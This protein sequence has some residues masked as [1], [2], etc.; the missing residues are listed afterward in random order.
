MVIGHTLDAW[1]SAEEAEATEDLSGPQHRESSDYGDDSGSAH[2][3]TDSDGDK[4]VSFE[5]SDD[6][7]SRKAAKKA[8]KKKAERRQSSAKED[9]LTAEVS[10]VKSVATSSAS[11]LQRE[12]RKNDA[13]IRDRAEPLPRVNGDITKAK[14]SMRKYEKAGGLGKYTVT[15]MIHCIQN[16]KEDKKN[17]REG[18]KWCKVSDRLETAE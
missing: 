12:V 9:E 10:R 4:G 18:E 3:S 16:Q 7:T 11:L 8:R 6:S 15:E 5:E 1:G 17:K 13:L 2:H 14:K